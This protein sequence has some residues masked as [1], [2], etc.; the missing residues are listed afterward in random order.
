[1]GTPLI[2]ILMAVYE[3]KLEWLKE[4]LISLNN[5]SYSRL[6][7]YIRDDCS[8]EVSFDDIRLLVER[9]ITSFPYVVNRN[10]KNIGSNKTFE[11]LTTEAEGEYFAYCDQDDIWMSGKL[12]SLE[13]RIRKTRA[14]LVCSDVIMI[15]EHGVKI[16]NSIREFRPRHIFQEGFDLSEVLIYKNF[17]I[18]CTML[19]RSEIAK[20]SL[21]FALSMV[22]DHYLAFAC[23]IE[24]SISVYPQPLVLYRQHKTNQTGILINI[25]NKDDYISNHLIPFCNRIK[26]LKQ[27]YPDAISEK[28]IEWSEARIDN[29]RKIPGSK[30]RLFRLRSLNYSTTMFELIAL[31]MPEPIFRYMIKKIQKGWI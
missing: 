31:Q 23:S 19:I 9:C 12:M 14:G 5:Q 16:G 7:L 24:H 6:H 30:K 13:E 10:E 8:E 17:V 25:H 21:P 18:G 1:M 29:I 26:E 28:T 15:D 11:R 2:S 22:H 20:R 27:R 4:Q 3:P